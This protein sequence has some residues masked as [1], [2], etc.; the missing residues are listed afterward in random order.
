MR[1]CLWGGGADTIL[2]I[3]ISVKLTFFCF[4]YCRGIIADDVANK[5]WN[6]YAQKYDFV[7]FN[8]ARNV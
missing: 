5:N 3:S 1:V 2:A 4:N 6:L 7:P 8:E